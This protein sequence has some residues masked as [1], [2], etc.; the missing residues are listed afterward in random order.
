[1]LTGQTVR[2]NLLNIELL[3][4]MCPV[5]RQ[6]LSVTAKGAPLSCRSER[7]DVS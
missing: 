1:M 2:E 4:R 7:G 5:T 3:G 6:S